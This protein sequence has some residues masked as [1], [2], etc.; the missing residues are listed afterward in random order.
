MPDLNDQAFGEFVAEYGELLDELQPSIMKLEEEPGRIELIEEPFRIL[1]SIKGMASFFSLN[2]VKKIA[3]QLEDL[4]TEIKGDRSTIT[5]GVIDV[6]LQGTQI[7]E[8]L[9]RDITAGEKQLELTDREEELL[10]EA[11]QLKEEGEDISLFVEQLLDDL[12]SVVVEML[13]TDEIAG[14]HLVESLNEKIMEAETSFSGRKEKEETSAGEQKIFIDHTVVVDGKNIEDNLAV[15]EKIARECLEEQSEELPAEKTREFKEKLEA[16]LESCTGPQGKAARET[17]QTME[18]ELEVFTETTGFNYIL[19]DSFLKH[20]RS[21]KK[22]LSRS[23]AEIKSEAEEKAESAGGQKESRQIS[24]TF[25]IEENRV[26]QFMEYVGELIITGEM[27]KNVTRELMAANIDKSLKSQLKDTNLSF[28]KLSDNLQTSLLEIRRV[29]IKK[30]L[31]KYPAVARRLAGELDKEVEVI[32]EGEETE[33]DKSL[34]ETLEVPL[35]HLVRNAVDHGIE[36]PEFRKRK[37]K[38]STGTIKIKIAADQETLFIEI[39]DDGSG[40]NKEAIKDKILEKGLASKKELENM[41]DNDIFQFLF[42]SG[43]STAE[44]VSE[45]SGRGVG[46]DA[47]RE[48]LREAGGTIEVNSEEGRGSRWRMELPRAQMVVVEEGLVV[49]SGREKFVVPLEKVYESISLNKVKITRVEGRGMVVRL[50]EKLYPVYWLGEALQTG[51]FNCRENKQ[52]EIVLIVRDEQ[53]SFALV[54]DRILDRKKVVVQD[55]GPAFKDVGYS[56]GCALMGDGTVSLI[57]DPP[58]FLEIIGK[59]EN[60]RP[61]NI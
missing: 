38:D 32:L 27:Y 53:A 45:V 54:V 50:R 1:H 6:L 42:K 29:P 51:G 9:Y 36:S 52:E 2:P 35:T 56:A 18:E 55:L 30:L 37:G 39:S 40:L 15:L 20:F 33:V 34:V 43:F 31:K 46:M 17:L 28:Q 8:R 14:H 23:G 25:R 44:E 41:E 48:K 3:H 22:L 5:P 24:R 58:G 10:K 11:Q 47:V 21:L 7:L 19:A 61:E 49:S 60:V 4:L 59:E 26:D 16:L 13:E 57:I 12:K